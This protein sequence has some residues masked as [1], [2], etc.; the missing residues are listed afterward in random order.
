M[1]EDEEWCSIYSRAALTFTA[2]LLAAA[3]LRHSLDRK[4][5]RE[6]VS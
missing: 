2:Q 1:S 4:Q 6:V 3:K 5:P